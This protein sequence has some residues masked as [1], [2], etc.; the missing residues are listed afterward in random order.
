MRDDWRSRWLDMLG[1]FPSET[2]PLNARTQLV[3]D[4]GDRVK[5]AVGIEC[6][7]V[8]FQSEAVPG[9]DANAP[10]VK[11]L[12]QVSAYLLVPE[13]AKAAPGPAILCIHSTTRGS[14]KSRIVGLTPKAESYGIQLGMTGQQAVELML[15]TEG[16]PT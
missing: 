2:P 15:Q 6:H 11:A 8:T 4:Y 3:E 13:A 16:D 1:P 9:R 14:G 7:H 12:C 5:D 10:D